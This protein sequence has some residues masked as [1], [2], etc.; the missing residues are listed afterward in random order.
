MAEGEELES[1]LLL[2]LHRRPAEL[3]GLGKVARAG[4]AL[5]GPKAAKRPFCPGA[6]LQP[7]FGL[8]VGAT[9]SKAMATAPFR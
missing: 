8:A 2:V 9:T 5:P 4:P 7:K 1:N 3:G 6:A